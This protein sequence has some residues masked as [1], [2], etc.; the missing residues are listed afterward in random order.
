MGDKKRS[1]NGFCSHFQF[2]RKYHNAYKLYNF[3][4]PTSKNTSIPPKMLGKKYF[5]AT[6]HWIC[7]SHAYYGTKCFN[8]KHWFW[9][10]RWFFLMEDPPSHEPFWGCLPRGF[11]KGSPDLLVAIAALHPDC[12]VCGKIHFP[13]NSST[14]VKEMSKLK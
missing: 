1:E 12:G 14:R 4:S 10:Y 6:I 3:Y 11:L 13:T 5:Y 2:Y 8:E 7:Y 9:L